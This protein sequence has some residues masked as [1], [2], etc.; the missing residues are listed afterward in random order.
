MFDR[1]LTSFIKSTYLTFITPKTVIRSVL[2]LNKGIICDVCCEKCILLSGVGSL[3][4]LSEGTSELVL[5]VFAW[6]VPAVAWNLSSWVIDLTHLKIIYNFQTKHITHLII[7]Q[8]HS[9]SQLKSR[10]ILN[11]RIHSII[12]KYMTPSIVNL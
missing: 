11:R 9:N 3:G 5:T 7:Y 6:N 10:T 8:C 12:N 4:D 1:L 2:L